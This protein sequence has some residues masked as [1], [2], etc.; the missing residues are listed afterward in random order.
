MMKSL[1]LAIVLLVLGTGLFAQENIALPKNEKLTKKEKK[2]ERDAIR[3]RQFNEMVALIN[4]RQFVLEAGYIISHDGTKFS[5]SSNLNFIMVDSAH[6]V[7]QSGNNSGMGLNDVGGTTASGNITSWKVNT[8]EKQR[9]LNLEMGVSTNMGLINMTVYI[10]A[11]GNAT[12]HLRE[13]FKLPSADFVGPLIPLTK[14]TV[15]KGRAGYVVP[16]LN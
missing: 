7:I 5:V 6:A 14:S 11:S 1:I 13:N 15:F 10:P 12:A 4:S 3:T 8:N 2:E 16:G 9:T